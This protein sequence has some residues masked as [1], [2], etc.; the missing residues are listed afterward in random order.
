[1]E[2]TIKHATNGFILEYKTE[3]EVSPTYV[4]GGGDTEED[5]VKACVAMLRQIL[6]DFGPMTSRYSKHRI[7]ITVAPGDKHEDFSDEH[8]KAIFGEIFG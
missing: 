2:V 5:E 7:Y 8:S 6:D 4:Y 1:M 3:D